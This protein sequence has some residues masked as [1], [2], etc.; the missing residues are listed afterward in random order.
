MIFDCRESVTVLRV[1]VTA[2]RH[3]GLN[4]QCSSLNSLFYALQ[5]FDMVDERSRE[6]CLK[7]I[8]LVQSLEHPNIIRYIDAFIE[9]NELMLIFEYAEVRLG[10]GV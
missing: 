8:G 6:K 5:I 4:S 9:N 3:D 1:D 2:L 7:E 10:D